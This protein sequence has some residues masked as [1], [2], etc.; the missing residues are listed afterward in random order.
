MAGCC[1]SIVCWKR[2][3]LAR[4][5]V[6]PSG[7]RFRNAPTSRLKHRNT[8]SLLSRGMLP[9]KWSRLRVE[10]IDVP[11]LYRPLPRS[12]K[13]SGAK[14]DGRPEKHVFDARMLPSPLEAVDRR[15]RIGGD[16]EDRR[17]YQSADPRVEPR[18]QS[19]GCNQLQQRRQHHEE[20]GRPKADFVEQLRCPLDIAELCKRMR[21]QECSA[22]NAD[23]AL[24]VERDAGGQERH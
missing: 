1:S 2:I 18:D 10:H 16:N 9:T 12:G 5:P 14:T 24:G 17:R 23:G 7:T 22:Y 13:K 11:Q 15:D 21:Q 6:S 19:D 8:S 4:S 3:H 20:G